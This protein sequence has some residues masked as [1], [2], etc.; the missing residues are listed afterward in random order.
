MGNIRE[1]PEKSKTTEVF[2]HK[3]L[4]YVKSSMCGWR[5]FM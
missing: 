4:T 5:S 2:R 3:T 1:K